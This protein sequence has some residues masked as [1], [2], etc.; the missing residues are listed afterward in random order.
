MHQYLSFRLSHC[1]C[2]LFSSFIKTNNTVYSSILSPYSF[3]PFYSKTLPQNNIYLLSS[4]SLLPFSLESSLFTF[5][6]LASPCSLILSTSMTAHCLHQFSDL[7][8]NLIASLH[9]IGPFFSRCRTW[10]VPWYF[11]FPQSYMPISPH[12]P[13]LLMLVWSQGSVLRLFFYIPTHS[14]S[15][16][17]MF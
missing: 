17:P 13:D 7:V 16:D 9:I 2:M 14:L 12:L 8:L 5:F 15:F 4:I 11:L 10:H 6:I 1:M 3:L